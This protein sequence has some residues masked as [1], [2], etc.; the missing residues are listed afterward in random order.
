MPNPLVTTLM[1]WDPDINPEG[2]AEQYKHTLTIGGGEAAPAS[3]SKDGKNVA[4][5]PPSEPFLKIDV[6]ANFAQFV[7]N[8]NVTQNPLG[9]GPTVSSSAG[10]A[11]NQTGQRIPNNTAFLLAWQVGAKFDFPKKFY[12][13]LTPTLYN[14]TGN[15]NVFDIHYQGGSPDVTNAESLAQNQ[16]GIN[17][18][19]V[20]DLPGQI[21][22]KLWGV[23]MRVFGDFAVN[24]EADD[25]ANA[26]GHP[27]KG[28]DRYAYQIGLGIGQLKKKH[29]WEISAWWQH[30][31]QYSLD[32]NL[33]DSD[34]FDSQ[35]NLQGVAVRAG[36][37]L[38]DA[39]VF[40]LTYAYA[41]QIDD[42]LGTGGNGDIS[43]NPLNQ[44]QIFQ[45]DLSFK[46]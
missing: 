42:A 22:W 31:D 21:G 33:V 11:T 26:A 43:I 12:F 44:Y 5:P 38:A 16:T 24:F 36:Y 1:V 2:L 27:G 18:L 34:L 9:P 32:P 13:Q 25:R 37:M 15:G 14:Y 8:G 39:V 4:P 6:F 28:G 17:S 3:Y 46:F 45:A 7:Y 20:F 29:D 23:P 41:W 10:S 35:L 40:N 19:L 30:Q